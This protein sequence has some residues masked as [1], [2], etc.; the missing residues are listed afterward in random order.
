MVR[1]LL[2]SAIPCNHENLFICYDEYDSH[3]VPASFLPRLNIDGAPSFLLITFCQPHWIP[4]SPHFAFCYQFLFNFLQKNYFCISFL[5]SSFI[6]SLLFFS[7]IIIIVPVV[8]VMVALHRQRKM[9][10]NFSDLI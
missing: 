10:I 5:F 3:S 1:S 4:V 2:P 6:S 7:G 9:L 8:M